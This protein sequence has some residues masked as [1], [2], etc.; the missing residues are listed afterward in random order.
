MQQVKMLFLFAPVIM[1]F[2]L[3]GCAT[4]PELIRN[5]PYDYK[6]SAIFDSNFDTTWESVIRALEAHPIITIE[7]VSGILL[8]DWVQGNSPLY[9]RKVY[10]PLAQRET[11]LAVGLYLAQLTPNVLYI[12]HAL[13]EGPAFSSG[14]RSGDILLEW[15]GKK[16]QNLSDFKKASSLMTP[17]VH[18][19]VLRYGTSDPLLFDVQPKEITFGYQYIPIKTRYKLNVRATTLGEMKTEVKIINYEE[20]DFGHYTQFGWQPNYQVIESSTL[21]EKVILDAIEFEIKRK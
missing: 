14:I 17:K 6:V 12:A 1:V 5:N 10:V 4:G 11:K 8:T 16:I 13:E 18:I 20:G 7:K 3:S 9:L 2:L 19:K 15:N 21:R